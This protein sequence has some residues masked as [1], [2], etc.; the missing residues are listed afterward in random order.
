MYDLITYTRAI[1]WDIIPI[2]GLYYGIT[3]LIVAYHLWK[4]HYYIT[5]TKHLGVNRKTGE[6]VAWTRKHYNIAPPDMD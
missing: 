6:W 2:L 5:E 4:G 3:Y 1:L